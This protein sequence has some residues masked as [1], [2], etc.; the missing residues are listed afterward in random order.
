MKNNPADEI[1]R[2]KDEYCGAKDA[3]YE[4]EQGELIST[5]PQPP[6]PRVGHVWYD[7][8]NNELWVCVGHIHGEARWSRVTS[9]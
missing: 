6:R 9:V 3:E 4:L 2:V 8:T 7:T 5:A 1:S